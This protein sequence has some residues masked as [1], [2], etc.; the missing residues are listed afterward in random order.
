MLAAG[1]RCDAWAMTIS[2]ETP[3]FAA[4]KGRQQKTWA[5]GDYHMVAS[6]IVPVAERLCD[7]VDLR[8]GQQVLDVATG[9][10][11]VAIAAARR[12]CAVTGVDYVPS[13]LERA[14][15]RA[16]AE[17]LPIR[18]EEGDAEALPVS[19]GSFDVVLSTFGVMFAPNQEQAARELLRATRRGGRIG[20]AN[21]TPEGW[22]GEMLRIVGRHVAP[23]A[24]LR[25]PTRWGTETGL[26]E[27]FGSAVSSL[28]MTRQMFVWRFT[29]AEQYLD[30]FRSFY[31]PTVKAFEALP[32]QGQAALAADLLDAVERYGQH[33][34]GT[35]LVPAEYLEAVAI[36]D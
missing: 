12:F 14:R 15:D 16:A 7:T 18:F 3:D 27:L 2:T 21:W 32:E 36:K 10:G 26:R 11:N 28:E 5:S 25:P 23:P 31:G 35:L 13:L 24:G 6:V 8:A 17:A 4:I 22:I 29:S 19:D 30:L 1:A 20:L 33:V 34:D 9:S